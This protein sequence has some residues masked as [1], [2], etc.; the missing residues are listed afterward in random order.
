M[1][2]DLQKMLTSYKGMLL[3]VGSSFTTA[4]ESVVVKK[5]MS[6]GDEGMWQ[7]VWMSSFMQLGLYV[8]IFPLSHIYGRLM[9]Y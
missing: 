7:L 2:T 8:S 3:G 9:Q 6:K 5:F 1:L 4:V